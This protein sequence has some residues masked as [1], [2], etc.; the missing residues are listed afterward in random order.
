[1]INT[2]WLVLG[3][4][5]NN[6]CQHCYAAPSASRGNWMPT[7]FAKGVI[8]V[9]K[10]EART[11]LLIGGEPTLFPDLME[12][13]SFGTDNELKMVIVSNGRRMK[14][15]SFTND[16]FS[17]GL[18]RAVISLEGADAKT[19]NTI[20]GRKSFLDTING[21]K[22][23][24]KFG[25]VNTL[26]T[27]CKENNHQI[28]EIVKLAYELG[29]KKSVLNCAIPTFTQNKTLGEYCLN[30]IELADTINKVFAKTRENGLSFQ[31]NATFPLCLLRKEVLKESLQLDW[32]SV[33][34]H[35]YRGKG[36]VFDPDG[37][38]L[39]CTHFSEAPLIR[40]V[41][42]KD[43]TFSLKDTFYDIWN[44]PQNEVGEFR[45]RLWRYPA[46]K[47]AS[48]EYW[49]GCIGGCPL[50]WSHFDPTIFIDGQREEVI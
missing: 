9:L 5:C 23:C 26:T 32:V 21:I 29:V 38:I 12:I 49:G 48:C 33:G 41:M 16:L 19:H 36:I 22:N 28:F 13:I 50:L 47:C 10:K 37:N 34:C 17:C 3:Y 8:E 11:G 18:N 46:K 24:V 35:M 39:P 43:G 44:N 4:A 40:N 20:T 15:Q 25:S 31:L 1:M 2:F 7:S 6:R 30:P 45:S 14:N 42:E 27:I